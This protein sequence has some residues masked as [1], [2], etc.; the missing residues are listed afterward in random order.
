MEFDKSL[1]IPKSEIKG[2]LLNS[3]FYS[4][5]KKSKIEFHK[6]SSDYP[7]I[8]IIMPVYNQGDTI[9]KTIKS[10][11]LQNFSDFE[12]IIV[13]DCSTDDS[14]GMVE[15]YLNLDLR[16]KL[17]N[18][19]SNQG[20]GPARNF[21]LEH[22]AGQ[23]VRYCDADDFYPPNALNALITKADA[24]EYD[25]VAGNMAFFYNHNRKI[26]IDR[27]CS[28]ISEETSSENFANIPSL[29]QPF[30]FHR[31]LYRRQ[32]LM[33]NNI[34][35]PALRR[36]EDP[37]FL[38]EVLVKA[39][40]VA[41]IQDMTYIFHIRPRHRKFS[42]EEARDILCCRLIITEKFLQAG[43]PL[44]AKMNI[45]LLFT[46]EFN[47]P[48]FPLGQALELTALMQRLY[49]NLSMED[50]V[51]GKYAP[52]KINIEAAKNLLKQLENSSPEFLLK[53]LKTGLCNL[54]LRDKCDNINAG[55]WE[56]LRLMR[57][58]K[59]LVFER[60]NLKNKLKSKLGI[61]V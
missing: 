52:Y 46:S 32:F 37:V 54:D 49:E 11:L 16:I 59:M 18:M 35:F 31:I 48:D 61:K 55:A 15:K 13:N 19:P 40:S 27:E 17:L 10:I 34:K 9:E 50:I 5:L 57:I 41:T 51:A 24:G 23:Y 39:K 60:Q 3:K 56:R 30:H 22:A 53:N 14:C 8:S 26:I 33:D 38:T 36:G 12:L 42:F 47:I 43:K 6:A 20:P 21:G 4:W 44:I 2:K 29:W 25:I 7:R 45:M 58:L 28:F 1:K